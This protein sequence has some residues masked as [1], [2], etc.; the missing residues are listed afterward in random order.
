M[1][2][3]D[4][5]GCPCRDHERVTFDRPALF[6]PLIV[7]M[8]ASFGL[9]LAMEDVPYGVQLG[10]ALPYTCL[11]VLGTFSAQRG[12]QPYFF[13]CEIVRSIMRR[14]IRRHIGFMV[15]ISLLETVAMYASRF[16]PRS[17]LVSTGRDGSPFSVTLFIVCLS[18][19]LIQILTNRSLIERAHRER[20]VLLH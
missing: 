8:F 13:E 19:A 15:A 3:Q 9:L 16:M 5:L 14:L 7:V 10:S 6:L 1:A 4:S 20:G 11:C 18:V 17:W 12:Q 2:D